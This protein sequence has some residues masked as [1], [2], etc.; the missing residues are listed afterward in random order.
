MPALNS[1]TT[2]SL[3]DGSSV[4]TTVVAAANLIGQ[5]ARQPHAQTTA[6]EASQLLQVT[7]PLSNLT[8]LS[9]GDKLPT[10]PRELQSHES[11]YRRTQLRPSL[12][13]GPAPL[14]RCL[15]LRTPA[16]ENCL[17]LRLSSL[18][19]GHANKHSVAKLPQQQ[20]VSVY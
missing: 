10:Y 8:I 1:C 9:I 4:Y 20:H 11:S 18:Y 7:C 3:R 6:T 15:I 12:S 2:N 17:R 19:E 5:S 13:S 16:T 14:L